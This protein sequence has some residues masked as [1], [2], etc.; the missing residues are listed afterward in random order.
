M[1]SIHKDPTNLKALLARA[2]QQI[3]RGL[4]PAEIFSDPAIFDQEMASIF[5]KTWV[6]VAFESEIPD[7]GDFVT[8]SIGK[9]PVL[10]T[11]SRNGDINV[12]ANFCRHRG[13]QL[14]SAE[15]GNALNFRCP[16]HGWVYKN[17]GSWRGAPDKTLYYSTID[18]D[19]WGLLRAP[20][21]SS[22]H[23]LIFAC[24]DQDAPP[25]L[26]Y[27]SGAAWM[28]K[29]ILDLHPAGMTVM[30]P[31][32]RYRVRGN[33]KTA[34]EN[35]AGDTYHLNVAHRSVQTIEL[36][37]GF[38]FINETTVTYIAGNGHCFTGSNAATSAL[39]GYGDTLRREFDL[40]RFDDV[41]RE[42]LSQNPPTVGNIFPNLGFI[43]V[44]DMPTDGR[45]PSIY[46]SFRQFQPIS[47]HETEIVSWQ[48]KWNFEDAAGAEAAY[49]MGQ[50]SFG[51]AGIFEQ[52][53]AVLWEGAP[54]VGDSKWAQNAG[55]LFNM[56]L[57]MDHL[58]GA[59]LRDTQWRGPG[60]RYRGGVSEA[61]ARSF[62]SRWLADMTQTG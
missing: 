60:E 6:F 28:L 34:S 20:N 17:N 15:Q 58:G 9:D 1:S 49:S 53:D 19:A 4:S 8:R 18:K 26:E 35:F 29:T 41:Q 11:R 33:W 3:P 37:A 2:S 54:K 55:T 40:D 51:S 61:A 7:A 32:D 43:R 13:A 46:T 31:P 36:A 22:I 25:L 24:L 59:D 62:Y 56:Q 30:G 48:L 21:V 10:V 45:E 42:M 50:Y 57:G 47:A 5:A 14:C 16:Y 44:G 12:M 39:W 52:D 27:L 23:G 38:E